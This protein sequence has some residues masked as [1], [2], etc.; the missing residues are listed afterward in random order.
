MN[1]D[2]LDRLNKAAN[3]AAVAHRNQVRKSKST[4][5]IVHPLM[6]GIMLADAGCSVDVI[7]S[8]YLHDTIEDT[9]VTAED[10]HAEFGENVL[11]IVEGCSEPDKSAEWED[12]KQHT[13]E[14]LQEEA[15]IDVCMVTCADK[16]HNIRSMVLDYEEEQEAMWNRF[17][18]GKDKQQWYYTNL[19]KVLRK[20]LPEFPLFL[21]LEIEVNRL[22]KSE[23]S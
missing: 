13:I 15:S 20:R 22:F 6:V 12:R 10:I 16:L 17:N 2:K 3:F 23:S 5:Y 1:I 9:P 18:R 7:I 14:F 11:N 19:V 4:P 8:G 21:L